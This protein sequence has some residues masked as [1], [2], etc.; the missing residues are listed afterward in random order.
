MISDK[1]RGIIIGLHT[2]GVS[3]KAIAKKTGVP[4]TSVIRILRVEGAAQPVVKKKLGRPRKLTARDIRN[5]NRAILNNRHTTY[6]QHAIDLALSASARTLNRAANK[7]GFWLLVERRKSNLT[8]A[9]RQL[10]MTYCQAHLGWTADDWETR[11]HLWI[12]AKYWRYQPDPEKALKMHATGGGQAKVKRKKGEGLLEEC[13]AEGKKVT[14][15]RRGWHLMVGMGNGQVCLAE[16]YGRMNEATMV[17]LVDDHIRYAPREAWGLQ[18]GAVGTAY[19][20]WILLQDGDRSQNSAA[21]RAA[22][23]RRHI[24][25]HPDWPPNS[26][27]LNCIENLWPYVARE[28]AKTQPAAGE[29]R[30]AFLV[31]LKATLSATPAS[32]VRKLIRSMP[33][34]MRGCIDN[35]GGRVNY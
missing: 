27:D 29:S 18:A 10:R 32:F 8:D 13:V 24:K 15:G 34:R 11:I 4:R 9:Q 14:T 30:E 1:R 22:L 5:L 16:E 3:K 21:A 25:T 20:P 33:K 31:R 28:L 6:E 23:D 35:G 7:L 2:A 12:D 17:R 19:Q 26:P